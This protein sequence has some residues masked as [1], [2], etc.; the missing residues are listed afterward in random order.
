MDKIA[1]T[2]EQNEEGVRLDAFL[3]A[4]SG[5]SRSRVLRLHEQGFVRLNGQNP[6]KLGVKLRVGDVVLM[7]LP[8]PAPLETAATQMEIPI[9]YEDEDL[10]VINKPRGLVVHPSAGHED[11]TLVNGLLFVVIF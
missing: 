10:I 6:A 3:A 2:V 7:E 11:D 5:L 1:K 9:V 8:P 4:L